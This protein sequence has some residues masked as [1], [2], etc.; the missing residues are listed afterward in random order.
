MM[1]M[2]VLFDWV[3]LG[4]S[5]SKGL[6]VHLYEGKCLWAQILSHHVIF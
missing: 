1:L 3:C 5:G 6:V 4:G 2:K